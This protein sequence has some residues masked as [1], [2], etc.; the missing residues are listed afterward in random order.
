MGIKTD[1]TGDWRNVIL[2]PDSRKAL[3]DHGLPFK[4]GG[5]VGHE[6]EY[7]KDAGALSRK[8]QQWAAGIIP[9]MQP[10]LQQAEAPYYPKD[11]E[12]NGTGD[13]MRH[14]MFQAG[15]TN[16]YGELPAKAIGWLH[17]H[18]SPGQPDAEFNMDMYNDQLGRQLGGLGLTQQ[19]LINRAKDMV[20]S[21]QAKTLTQGEDGY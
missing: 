18:L 7:V 4:K 21:G 12:H 5:T 17:E 15:L 19:E 10:I 3:Q 14:I 20:D 2:D 8:T 9:G 13:A 6:N 16:T 11:T 1:D